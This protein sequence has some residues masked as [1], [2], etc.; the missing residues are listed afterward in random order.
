MPIHEKSLIRP[1]NL[2]GKKTTVKILYFTQLLGL[3]L[4]LKPRQVGVQEN[5]SDSRALLKEHGL[6]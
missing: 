6:A 2:L 4:G 3:V 5:I 1:E